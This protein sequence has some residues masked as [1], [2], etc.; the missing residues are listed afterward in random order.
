MNN[1][2]LSEF[3]TSWLLCS[4][5]FPITKEIPGLFSG[6]F[7]RQHFYLYLFK[8]ENYK[9][10][11]PAAGKKKNTLAL[12]I[13]E[14]WDCAWTAGVF[15]VGPLW[16][17]ILFQWDCAEAKMLSETGFKE[18]QKSEGLKHSWI[19]LW[20]QLQEERSWGSDV[21]TMRDVVKPLI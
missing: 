12:T 7:R 16:G 20:N 2:F 3:E 11:F 14:K 6:H 10:N 17:M 9:E 4:N 18:E 21:I 5:L 8:A 1:Y 13:T 15:Q 19:Y